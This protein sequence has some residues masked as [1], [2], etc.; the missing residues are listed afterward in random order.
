MPTWRQDALQPAFPARRNDTMRTFA[1]LA[2]QQGSNALENRCWSIEMRLGPAT[3]IAVVL[4]FVVIGCGKQ[5]TDATL[6]ILP[7]A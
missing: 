4:S 3:Q 1:V 2:L 7:A 5:R 6:A